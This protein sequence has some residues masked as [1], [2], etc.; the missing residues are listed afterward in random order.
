MPDRV[1]EAFDPDFTP[2]ADCPTF[3][4]SGA[5]QYK[6]DRLHEYQN[7]LCEA[8]ITDP[9]AIKAFSA[10]LMQEGGAWNADTLGDNGCSLG[11]IQFNACAHFGVKALKFLE[12]NPEWGDYRYQLRW[13][14]DRV[15]E[16]MDIYDGDIRLSV[17]H[18]NRPASARAGKDTARGYYKN[19]VMRHVKNLVA[20]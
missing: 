15:V 19:E 1:V 3:T 2:K 17:I 5:E 7:M 11:I 13:M 20:D 4:W 18:H 10:Q 14:V 6:V 9:E 8:G 12:N 16:R